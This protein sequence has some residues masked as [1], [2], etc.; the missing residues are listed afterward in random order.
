MAAAS[1]RLR[2]LRT[3]DRLVSS[4][5][6]SMLKASKGPERDQAVQ[7]EA[8]HSSNEHDHGQDGQDQPSPAV[9]AV[10]TAD[11]MR[12]LLAAGEAAGNDCVGHRML[13]WSVT[14]ASGLCGGSRP[15]GKRGDLIRSWVGELVIRKW[16]SG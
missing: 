13:L 12:N 15:A 5:S 10:G 2:G 11:G 1:P 8:E 4:S 9:R 6:E 14:R 16:L 3:T 7:P